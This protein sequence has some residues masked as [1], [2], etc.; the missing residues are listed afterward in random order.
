MS[1][2]ANFSIFLFRIGVCKGLYV[3]CTETSEKTMDGSRMEERS[4]SF[5]ST[6]CWYQ[7]TAGTKISFL[8]DDDDERGKTLYTKI[9]D[10]P[11]GQE[12]RR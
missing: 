11:E 4:V 12:E 6:P 5:L 9:R 7:N 8:V 10:I 2:K 3:Y 1:T